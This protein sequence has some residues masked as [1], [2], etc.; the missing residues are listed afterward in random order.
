M[1]TRV[2]TSDIAET[3][4]A[5]FRAATLRLPADDLARRVEQL[6]ADKTALLVRVDDLERQLG[7]AFVPPVEFQ[8]SK[9]EGVV[10]GVLMFK[11]RVTP[12]DFVAAL[13]PPGLSRCSTSHRVI[14]ARLRKKLARFKI[15]IRTVSRRYYTLDDDVQ[16]KIRAMCPLNLAPLGERAP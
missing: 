1:R 13:Y 7:R 10:L 5:F 16:R 8:L 9:F 15:S 6:E 14:V 2:D 12:A 4:E 11:Q 3:K